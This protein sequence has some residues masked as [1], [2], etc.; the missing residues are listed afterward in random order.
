MQ[1]QFV[2][3]HGI[4]DCRCQGGRMALAH[5]PCSGD[6]H[7]RADGLDKRAMQSARLG[8]PSA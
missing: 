2:R 1:E 7:D 6:K 3:E 8:K 5:I 4:V